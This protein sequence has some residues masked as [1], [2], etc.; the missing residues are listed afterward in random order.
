MRKQPATWV[1]R[2]RQQI[3]PWESPRGANYG[4]FAIPYRDQVLRV[5]ISDGESWDHVSVSLPGRCP[6]W[7]EMCYVKTAFFRGDET[8]VQYHP[9]EANYVNHHPFCLHMWRPQIAEMPTPPLY[10]VGPR[11]CVKR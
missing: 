2:H 3:S 1:E 4:D 8:V 6:A 7:D 10:C 11:R 5:R 9:A